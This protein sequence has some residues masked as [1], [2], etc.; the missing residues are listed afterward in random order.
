[1]VHILNA[2]TGE[3]KRSHSDGAMQVQDYNTTLV[4]PALQ[5]VAV[6]A[7]QLQQL[8]IKTPLSDK[9][10]V[11]QVKHLV[12]QGPELPMHPAVE[13][14]LLP[15]YGPASPPLLC[16]DVLLRCCAE[17]CASA[18]TLPHSVGCILHRQAIWPVQ[19]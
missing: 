1:V 14:R 18:T 13:L 3:V 19:P 5:S 8:Q 10:H 11:I 2:L 15:I 9:C 16:K 12:G 4:Q 6:G 17:M 7:T